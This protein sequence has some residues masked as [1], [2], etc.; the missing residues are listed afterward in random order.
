M[1]FVLFVPVLQACSVCAADEVPGAD[2]RCYERVGDETPDAGDVEDTDAA[3]PRGEA[4]LHAYDAY[5]QDGVWTYA[6]DAGPVL[7]RASLDVTDGAATEPHPL[8]LRDTSHWQ[9]TASL[10]VVPA[11]EQETGVST[12]FPCEALDMLTWRIQ[13]WDDAGLWSDCVVWGADP[14]PWTDD[15]CVTW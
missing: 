15:R 8:A 3:E 6:A 13:V 1:R 7:S 4:R 2:G 9:L 14:E 11:E 10:P 5:C 12:R